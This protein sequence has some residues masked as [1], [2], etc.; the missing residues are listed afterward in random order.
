MDAHN[1]C[2]Y[3][4]LQG[5]FSVANNTKRKYDVCVYNIGRVVHPSNKYSA[6]LLCGFEELLCAGSLTVCV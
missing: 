6:V 3:A 4:M 2:N 1:L 5:W